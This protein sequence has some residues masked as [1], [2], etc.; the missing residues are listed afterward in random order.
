MNLF[1]RLT[2][3]DRL[4][5]RLTARLAP[6]TER[7]IARAAAA[8]SAQVSEQGVAATIAADGST[9][10]VGSTDA[11]AVQRETGTL[12]TPPDPWLTPALAR[13]RRRR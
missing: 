3:A 11:A 10:R 12:D 8:V 7:G 6:V 5:R 2:G 4:A 1:V 13:L 9:V